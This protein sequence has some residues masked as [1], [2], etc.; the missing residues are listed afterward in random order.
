MPT[1]SITI[2]RCFFMVR[3]KKTEKREKACTEDPRYVDNR[4]TIQSFERKFVL[5]IIFSVLYGFIFVNYIDEVTIGSVYSG[6]H[7]WLFFLYFFPFMILTLVFPKNWGLTVGLGLI[8]SL[9]NDV[10]YGFMRYLMGLPVDLTRY[11]T[12]WLI[13]SSGK[14]FSLNLGFTDLPVYS[15]MMA[16]SIY[17]R[18]VIVFFLLMAWKSQA[19]IRC[20]ED[21]GKKRDWFGRLRK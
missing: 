12:L 3:L 8:A 13:P 1:A 6:Y 10:F 4:K 18:I 11:Y 14:L 21:V 15:W 20:L 19:S 17:G 16:L 5:Y 2:F 9:M 7:V